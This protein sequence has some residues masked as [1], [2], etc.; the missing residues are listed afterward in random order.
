MAATLM[1]QPKHLEDVPENLAEL[2]L[3][4]LRKDPD[5]RFQSM[6]EVKIALEDLRAGWIDGS[7]SSMSRQPVASRKRHWL[8]GTIA[9][10]ALG[11]VL[12]GLWIWSRK[13]D[14]SDRSAPLEIT[15]LTNEGG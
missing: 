11:C 8:A 3:R 12:A 4:C 2:I 1:A 5:R 9:G 10:F 15:R 13:P 14:S 7:V 6:V